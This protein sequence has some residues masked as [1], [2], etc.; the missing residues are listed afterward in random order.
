MHAVTPAFLK[1]LAVSHQMVVRVDAYYDGDLTVPDLPILDG[2]V[3]V[4]RGSKIRRTLSLTVADPSYLPWEP[5]DPLATYGQE[6][7][8]SRGIRYSNGA[9]E[10]VPLGTFRVD[11]PQGDTL[12]GPVTVTGGSAEAHLVDDPFQVPTSTRGYSGCFDAIEALIRQTLSDAVIVNLTSDTR[13]PTCAVADWDAGND[14]WDAVAQIAQAMQA[15]IYV[16]ATNRFVVVDRPD[17]L[18]DPVVWEIAEGEGGT[19]ISSARQMSRKGVAN[20]VVAVGENTA[21]GSAPVSAVAK[22]T[23]PTSPTMWGGPYGKVTKFIS[24]PLWTTSGS[25]LSAA[26]Y[27]LAEAIAPN[28]QTS[29]SSLPN[30]ALEGGDVIRVSHVGRKE[31]FLIQSLAI[32]LSVDGTFGITLRGGKEDV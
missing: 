21:S 3:T 18:T 23:D 29:I 28:I 25:C 7:V 24:S 31:L 17:V 26:T 15:E 1:T 19:L 5:T 2:A 6:L 4:D 10:W 27:A 30:P 9:T 16:D 12:Y 32:P 14:R 13:N 11:E 22:D 8:V 20:A